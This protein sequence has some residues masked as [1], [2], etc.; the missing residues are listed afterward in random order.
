MNKD[1]KVR[2]TQLEKKQ[3]ELL[4]EVRKRGYP[5]L[6]PCALSS[7]INGHVV[8]PQADAVLT[9]TREILDE[10]EKDFKKAI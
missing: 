8:G 6:A 10:W 1:I 9:I 2:L 5:R 4:N 7:Y 3:I